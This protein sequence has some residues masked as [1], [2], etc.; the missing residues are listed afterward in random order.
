MGMLMVRCPKTP[1]NLHGAI[2]RIQAIQQHPRVFRQ[3]LLSTL[4]GEA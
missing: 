3:H 2:Y 1:S 4:R